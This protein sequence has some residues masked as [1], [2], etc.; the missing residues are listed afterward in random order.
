MF[1]TVKHSWW[2]TVHLWKLH[3]S[4]AA[5]WKTRSWS[6]AQLWQMPRWVCRSGR[7]TE[8]ARPS[9]SSVHMLSFQPGSPH[10]HTLKIPLRSVWHTQMGKHCFA[11]T[12]SVLIHHKHGTAWF[13]AMASFWQKYIHPD[14]E[15]VL[16]LSNQPAATF[17]IL[18]AIK[19]TKD[20]WLISDQL[21]HQC[22][23]TDLES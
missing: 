5:V 3:T 10:L 2:N 4:T 16:L 12:A 20:S 17:Y 1:V 15:D 13:W 11:H 7:G 22:N 9:S 8:P 6:P 23:T 14:T 18:N 19:I 21:L